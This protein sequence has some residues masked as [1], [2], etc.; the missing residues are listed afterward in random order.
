MTRDARDSR[1]NVIEPST[2]GHA[3]DTGPPEGQTQRGRHPDSARRG[4]RSP[5][6]RFTRLLGL[7]AAT[8]A[9]LASLTASAALAAGSPTVGHV[10]VNNNTA[11][12]NTVAGFDRHADGSL[13]PIAG[14]PFDA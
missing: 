7:M 1:G 10:Y 14:S 3:R 13:S 9:L 12:R 8:T 5:M 4:G 6:H 11:G 2:S